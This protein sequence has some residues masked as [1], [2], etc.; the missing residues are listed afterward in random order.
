VSLPRP[1]S[2]ATRAM[3]EFVRLSHELWESLKAEWQ[4]QDEESSSQ[5]QASEAASTHA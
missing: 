4:G 1:R 5:R 2:S 3:P